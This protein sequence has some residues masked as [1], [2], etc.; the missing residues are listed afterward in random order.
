[1]RASSPDAMPQSIGPGTLTPLVVKAQQRLFCKVD[2]P[3]SVCFRV[4]QQ[5][6]RGCRLLRCR[7]GSYVGY[8][9]QNANIVATAVHDPTLTLIQA[10]ER[11]GARG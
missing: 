9:S 2:R 10:R 7:V 4:V 1:M 5:L 11:S 8:T 3:R 6:A